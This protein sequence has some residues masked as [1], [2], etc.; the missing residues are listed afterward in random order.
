MNQLTKFVGHNR[1]KRRRTPPIN[2]PLLGPSALASGKVL[3]LYVSLSYR[4]D[5]SMYDNMDNVIVESY[6]IHGLLPNHD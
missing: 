1:Y 6:S 2:L 3:R 5:I 4:L